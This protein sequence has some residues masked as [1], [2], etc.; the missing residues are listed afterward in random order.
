MLVDRPAFLLRCV[1]YKFIA[2]RAVQTFGNYFK[3]DVS[4]SERL[5]AATRCRHSWLCVNF[6]AV[7]LHDSP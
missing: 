1:H 2:E 4:S 5:A 7:K 6:V 3:Y